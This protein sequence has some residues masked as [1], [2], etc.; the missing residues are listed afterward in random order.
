MSNKI[1]SLSSPFTT[2]IE[3]NGLLIHL[4]PVIC[5]HFGFIPIKKILSILMVS[6]V[7]LKNHTKW[8]SLI[9]WKYKI[10]IVLKF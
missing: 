3:L 5:D 4:I 6:L 10:S 7:P 8:W 2:S 9:S 1:F